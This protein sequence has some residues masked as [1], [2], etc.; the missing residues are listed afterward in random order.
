L[1]ALLLGTL[2]AG[3]V[4]LANPIP[5]AAQPQPDAAE[6]ADSAYRMAHGEGYTTTL[7]DQPNHPQ[8]ANPPRYSIGYPLVLAPFSLVGLY[9]GNVQV[10]AKLAAVALVLVVGWAAY[11]AGGA[12]SATIAVAVLGASPFEQWSAHLVMSDALSAALAVALIPLV[13][14]RNRPWV[15]YVAGFAAGYGVLVRLSALVVLA[16]VVVAWPGV[17]RLRVIASS[18]PPLLVLAGYQWA[19]FG[20][21]WRT[22]YDYWLPGLRSFSFAFITAPTGPGDGPILF[23]DRFHGMLA[24]WACGNCP[25]PGPFHTFPDW[26]FY[27]L[28]VTGAFWVIT[29]P[30]LTLLGAAEMVRTWRVPAGRFVMIAVVGQLVLYMP[31]FYQSARFV[32]PAILMLSVLA[33]AAIPRLAA[34]SLGRRSQVQLGNRGTRMRR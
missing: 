21:P 17:N 23:A 8:G 6:Y 32:A 34:L 29:P 14:M 9:P 5:I 13:M 33:A 16:A 19:T 22:G 15:A 25:N 3:R 10:G 28:V 20:A 7:R 30:M 2:V 27:G 1:V 26:F 24:A 4:L 31:Y 12:W 11:V 18:V